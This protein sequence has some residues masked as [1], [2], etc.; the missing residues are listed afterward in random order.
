M[1]WVIALNRPSDVQEAA[2]CNPPPAPADPNTPPTALGRAGDAQ[3]Y[4]RRHPRQARRHQDPGPQRQRAGRPGRRGGRCAARSRF[5]RAECRQRPRVR[6]DPADVPGPDPVRAVRARGRG[7]GLAGRA[8]HRVVPGRAQRR[9]GG[10]GDRHRVLRSEPRATTSTPCSPACA[11]TRRRRPTRRCW[12]RSTPP[13]A[14]REFRWCAYGLRALRAPRI[15]AAPC[16]AHRRWR[17]PTATISPGGAVSG[18]QP[19]R[20]TG[21]GGDQRARSPVPHM[22]TVLV[23]GVQTARPPPCTGRVRTSRSAGCRVRRA[24]ARRGPR[25]ASRCSA[26]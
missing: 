26:A 23:V 3:R 7:R 20:R 2:A 6:D 12:R 15:C 19:Q 17:A 13:P 22:H 14:R 18:R 4:D 21:L 24:A 8:V 9:H 10:S 16:P 1:V 11:R 5:R 25:P